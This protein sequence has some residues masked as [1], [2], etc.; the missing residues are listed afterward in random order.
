VLRPVDGDVIITGAGADPGGG[1]MALDHAQLTQMLRTMILIREFDERAIQLRLA[2]KMPMDV[3][4][5]RASVQKTGRLVIV[6]EAPATCSAA[7][8]IAALVVED[9]E[10]FRSLK[11]PVRRV[12]AMPVPVPYSPPLEQAALPSRDD[13]KTAVYDVLKE[14]PRPL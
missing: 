13:I 11:A 8:E 4:A 2:G 1:G 6:D 9:R 14:S 10:T 7:A 3:D 5:V 12:C